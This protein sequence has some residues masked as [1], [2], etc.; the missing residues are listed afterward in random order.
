MTQTLL[1]PAGFYQNLPAEMDQMGSE[2]G[3]GGWPCSWLLRMGGGQGPEESGL[4][5]IQQD[6][7]SL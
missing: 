2:A 1:C 3:L 4:K 6:P 7:R 5:W